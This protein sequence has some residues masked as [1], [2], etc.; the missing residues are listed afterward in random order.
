MLIYFN[1]ISEKNLRHKNQLHTSVICISARQ[2]YVCYIYTKLQIMI[3]QITCII[4]NH[5]T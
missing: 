1:S 2:R 3:L 5:D 4:I